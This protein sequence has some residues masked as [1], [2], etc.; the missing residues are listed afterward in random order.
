MSLPI[1]T[2]KRG[3]AKPFKVLLT[4]QSGNNIDPQTFIWYLSV[5]KSFSEKT[6]DYLI[7]PTQ[8]TSSGVGYIQWDL[9]E[10][11]WLNCPIGKSILEIEQCDL[12]G[13]PL[14]KQQWD[15]LITS[16]IKVTQTEEG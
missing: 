6:T 2:R 16:R 8:P 14:D 15:L 11:I 5:K 13:K 12:N 3:T 7:E 1:I 10:E 4:D 9:S